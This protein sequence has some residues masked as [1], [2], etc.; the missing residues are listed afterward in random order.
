MLDLKA[1]Y[2]LL[3]FYAPS[4]GH[5]QKELPSIDSLYKAD[6]K[7][8]GVKV[9]TVATEGTD[10]AITDFIKKYKLED[11]YNTWDPAHEG[12]WRGKYDVYSTPTIYLLDEKKIIR[13]KRLDHSNIVGLINNL[14]RINKS[15]NTTKT[16]S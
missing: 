1:N 2:T 4:C 7:D 13:G 15:K 14:E 5:C 6:L 9:Y 16:K 12:D 10:S 8:K 3:V 11:F